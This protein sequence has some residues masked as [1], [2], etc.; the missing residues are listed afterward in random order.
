MDNYK[1]NFFKKY[2]SIF[3]FF[4]ITLS[5]F[6]S[7]SIDKHFSADGSYY[8]SKILEKKDFTKVDWTRQNSDYL[9]QWMIV[10]G[11][12]LGI[13]NLN[14]LN[15]LFFAGI[16]SIYLFSFLISWFVLS[17]DK[18]YMMI[19]PIFS[20]IAVNLSSD[21][22]LVGESQVLALLTWPILFLLLKNKLSSLE[23]FGLWFLLISYIFIYPSA[24]F[25]SLIFIGLII[26]RYFKISNIK[27][28]TNLVISLG[29]SLLI[30]LFSFYSIIFPRSL[31]NSK[32]FYNGIFLVLSN[33]PA[34][35]AILFILIFLVGV[36]LKKRYL[37]YLS[38][39]VLGIYLILIFVF[40]HGISALTSCSSRTLTA[41]F[42]P[43][44]M[45]LGIL[46]WFYEVK[47]S[48][49]AYFSV[50][51]FV[52]IAIVGNIYYS[53]D[54]KNYKQ[55]FVKVLNSNTGFI[56]LEKT[57][58]SNNPYSW[59]WT[60][61][62][63]SVLWSHECVNSIVLNKAGVFEPF[64]PHEKLI[65]KEYVNYTHSFDNLNFNVSFC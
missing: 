9:N 2:F 28:K 34:V 55:D 41:T 49:L 4:L 35:L 3:L 8:F 27:E 7:F 56:N 48:N 54:W 45:I 13:T 29:I 61:S 11:L 15:F 32:S 5:L 12:K 10:L 19:F 14:V 18:K 59:F 62:V 17:S 47:M 58:I 50:V 16:Y 63:L 64:D 25:T 42:L 39:G 57:N 26:K 36:F 60:N 24:M 21:Y 46:F 65:L 31:E 20:M 6:N 43:V 52:L 51:L 38:L 23:Q 37:L 40:N 1:L 30:M 22:I 33:W 44:L 53:N